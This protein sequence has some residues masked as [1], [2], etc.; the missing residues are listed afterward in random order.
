MA[1]QIP[2][3][4]VIN[5]FAGFGKISITAALPILSV[6]QVQACP[7]PT[8]V[9][10]SH[11][12]YSPCHKADFTEHMSNY[13]QAWSNIGVTFD[14]LYLGYMSNPTQLDI[15]RDLLDKHAAQDAASAP[16]SGLHILKPDAKIIIDPVMGDH[17]KAY[18]TVTS[19]QIEKM[20]Q[21][22]K[23]AHLI[24]PNL[25]EI[26]ML[27]DMSYHSDSWSDAELAKMCSKLDPLHR[28]QIVI[29]GIHT[30]EGFCNYLW[31]KGMTSSITVPSAGAS[32]PGTGDMFASILSANALKGKNFAA[33]VQQASDFIAACIRDSEAAGTPIKEG[34][35]FE[36]NLS[37]LI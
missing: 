19:E 31:D 30:G 10:S 22:V 25:T 34:V 21:L 8:A 1:Q 3:L 9:L 12:A 4:A 7:L 14:G 5:S 11:L 24:T 33:S 13:L 16:H 29:T 23:R 27:T 26:C 17:G 36:Q 37:R 28:M 20:K 2:R 35:L 18:S 32:R 15:I 6:M